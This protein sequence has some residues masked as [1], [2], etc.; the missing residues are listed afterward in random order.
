M[1]HQY[2]SDAAVQMAKSIASFENDIKRVR[3][4][5]A[6]PDLLDQVRVDYYGQMTPISQ[7]ASVTVAPDDSRMLVVTP[8]EK[9]MVPVVEKAILNSD[10]G[11]NP[12]NQGQVIR[13]P[14]PALTRERRDV[15]VKQVRGFAEQARISIR[16]IRRDQL[17][18]IR[19][20]LKAKD[21]TEDEARQLEQQLQKKTDDLVAQVGELLDAKEQELIVV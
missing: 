5:R 9:P 18:R 2:V 12:A 15:L 1:A 19:S 20:D 11:L 14:L 13:I 17:N 21:L 3:T 10:L 4:G 16:N 8:W 6:H 7:V